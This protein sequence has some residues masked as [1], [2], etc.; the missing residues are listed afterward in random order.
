MLNQNLNTKM[1]WN[2]YVHKAIPTD[3]LPL[4]TLTLKPYMSKA[5]LS[6]KKLEFR[7]YDYKQIFSLV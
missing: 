7:V 3:G 6:F 2:I 1:K 4:N 5:S